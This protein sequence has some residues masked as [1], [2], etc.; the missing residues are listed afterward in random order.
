MFFSLVDL[1]G[2]LFDENLKAIRATTLSR[3]LSVSLSRRAN[4]VLNKLV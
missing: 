4:N 3:V 2:G 1:F